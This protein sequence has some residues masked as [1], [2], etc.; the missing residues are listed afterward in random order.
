VL[1]NLSTITDVPIGDFTKKAGAIKTIFGL[2]TKEFEKFGAAVNALDDKIGGTTPNI[3]EFSARVGAVGKNIGLS[4][5]EVAAFG[6]VFETVGISPERASTAFQNFA[7]QLFT[8]NAAGPK[9]RK[10]FQSMGFDAGTFGETMS[11]NPT[12]A[13][14]DF[15]V[16]LN[17]IEDPVQRSN[18]LLTIFGKSSSSEIAS[19][20]TQADKLTS[21]FN[22]A[23]D[24]SANLAKMQSEVA[25]KMNDPA[26]QA[27]VLQAQ[28]TAI[29]IQIGSVL[30]PLMSQLLQI[31]N[32]LAQQF[33]A[34]L[35]QNPEW[36]KFFVIAAGGVAVLGPVITTI[37][38]LITAVGAIKG[39]VVGAAVAM[40]GMAGITG[41]LSGVLGGAGAALAALGSALVS[42]PVLIT[43]A[44]A[45][46]VALVFNLGGCRDILFGIGSYLAGQLVSAISAAKSAILSLA[47]AAINH[48][49]DISMVLGTAI[50]AGI[51][52]GFNALKSLTSNL[53]TQVKGAVSQAIEAIKSAVPQF[54]NAGGNLGTAI[55]TGIASGFNALKSLT[56]NLVTQVKGAVSQAIEAIKSAV[57]QFLN[58]GGNLMLAFAQGV[59]NSAAAAYNAVADS[60][61]SVRNLLPSSPAKEGPL[62]D[63][64]KSGAALLGTFAS[65]I[66]GDD[67]IA[68]LTSVLA[69]IPLASPIGAGLTAPTPALATAGTGANQTGGQT[70]NVNYTQNVQIQ[71]SLNGTE[72]INALKSAQG[73]FL[74][75]LN[76]SDFYKNRKQA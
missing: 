74:E 38:A 65:N 66:N 19:L 9:V 24:S 33:S 53:V 67:L 42:V 49:R 44:I 29:G 25:S 55:N 2:N 12:K 73:Q 60:V 61:K 26:I 70:V 75:F 51:A 76:R 56:S 52:S 7:N 30:V 14:T 20:A 32:P 11:K 72:I 18:L 34:F 54:L 40:G 16:K 35:N 41:T 28:F 21:A 69:S 13:L 37:G 43:A 68:K 47:T 8:I 31:L 10:A 15:L 57:P 39:A 36:A 5:G 58:A 46:I 63:L 71:S 50:H 62:S 1:A 23:G 3:L 4:A 27:K 45:A 59:I 48:F 6:S 17:S 64:D 22:I